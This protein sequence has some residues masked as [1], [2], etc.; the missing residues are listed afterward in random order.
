MPDTQVGVNLIGRDISASK[1]L[2]NV[3]EQAHQTSSAF[4]RFGK[5]A[6]IA[7]LTMT[8]AFAATKTIDF[9]RDSMKGALEDQKAME[10]LKVAMDNVGLAGQHSGMEDFVTKMATA[11]GV[12][13]DQLRPA[14][15]ALVTATG[16]VTSSQR[17]LTEALNISAATGKDLGNVTNALAK[18]ATGHMGALTKLGIPLDAT[19]I[20]SKDLAAAQLVIDQRY[21]GQSAAAAQTYA[22]KMAILANAANEAQEKIGYALLNAVTDITG[23]I[24]GPSGAT[25]ALDKFA[26]SVSNVITKL[27]VLVEG[28]IAVKDKAAPVIN[29]MSWIND[30]VGGWS[31]VVAG[32]FGH[33]L[34]FIPQVGVAAAN[35]LQAAADHKQALDD[36][37]NGLGSG[38]GGHTQG[39]HGLV[40][41]AA[42]AA[43]AKARAEAKATADQLKKIGAGASSAVADSIS[44][45][46]QEALARA[47]KSLDAYTNS[48]AS[49]FG[50]VG[51]S[52]MTQLVEGIN[53]G[54]KSAKTGEAIRKQLQA[55]LA[56]VDDAF[57]QAREYGKGISDG[58]MRQLDIG[59][60]ADDWQARQDAVTAALKA[61]T[62][63][64]SRITADATDAER[65]NLAELQGVYQKAQEDAAAGGA[66]IVDAFVQQADKT[67]RFA[68]KMQYLMANH[69]NQTSWDQIAAMSADKGIKIADALI[70]GNMAEN[71]RRTNDA[72]G[73]VKI[74]ADQIGNQAIKTFQLAGI[75]MAISMFESM[76]K[77]V[78]AGSSRTKFLAAIASM[79]DEAQKIMAGAGSTYLP[80]AATSGDTSS[81]T[82]DEIALMMATQAAG[83]PVTGARATGGPVSAGGT[84][85]VGEHGP[86]LLTMPGDGVVTPNNRLGDLSGGGDIIVNVY[87]S[88][89]TE[90]DLVDALQ[91]GLAQRIRR[92]GG[93]VSVLGL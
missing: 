85:L 88:V 24:G 70:D 75:Q 86:E 13:D 1:A 33:D 32:V 65:A 61:V 20:K 84:Y 31:N 91:Q 74:V 21:G 7:G 90:R 6:A 14:L 66:S 30:H 26:D 46:M 23:K 55:G 38:M 39:S 52:V 93:D 60:V 17:M 69:L 48:Q 37:A 50:A 68:E 87:G 72:V 29:V 44:G 57:R 28:L 82:S 9:F 63:A 89:S 3:G 51:V 35:A 78:D 27:D 4:E 80:A 62:D 81:M 15:S 67:R 16:N 22:G 53:V 12:A 54:G 34:G 8:S 40:A 43:E 36:L 58:F 79:R 18:A 47:Q 71:I 10:G 25:E 59:A 56:K 5:V 83:L 49:G 92:R 77:I 76:Q 73:S 45:P 2:R 42:K 19:I 41:A 11:T 64:R